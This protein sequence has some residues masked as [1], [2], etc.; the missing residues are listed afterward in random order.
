LTTH[1]LE[2]AEQL[3]ERIAIINH[4]RLVACDTTEALL[5]RVDDKSLVL[6]LAQPVATVPEP[7]AALGFTSPAP[8]KLALRYAPSRTQ[9]GDLL[10]AVAAQG[11]TIRD[12]S[13]QETDLE[14]I[15]LQL[16]RDTGKAP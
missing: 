3:C 11:L 14:D 12:I 16:T 1:Y 13:S 8:G 6:T 10:A 2:E 9:L 5:R 4:G 15:F 7:L